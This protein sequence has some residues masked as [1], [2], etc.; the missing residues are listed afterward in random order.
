[1]TWE[2]REVRARKENGH[3]RPDLDTALVR[4]ADDMHLRLVELDDALLL[5][6][7][8]CLDNS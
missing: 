4:V 5:Q 8:N 1:M 3:I 6:L 2:S 7:L